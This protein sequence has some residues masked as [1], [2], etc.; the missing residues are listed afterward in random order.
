CFDALLDATTTSANRALRSFARGNCAD[1]AAVRTRLELPWGNAQCE[2]RVT[3]PKFLKRQMDDR[4]I[5]GVRC[6]RGLL[7]TKSSAHFVREPIDSAP[8]WMVS[9]VCCHRR[10]VSR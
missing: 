10:V 5:F 4:A 8:S 7:A 6:Q 3:R 1:Y 2:E 9:E